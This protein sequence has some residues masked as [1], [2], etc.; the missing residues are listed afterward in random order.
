[1]KL[2]YTAEQVQVIRYNPPHAAVRLVA[3]DWLTLHAEVERLRG[4][5]DALQT[6]RDFY[7]SEVDRQDKEHRETLREFSENS[8]HTTR[9]LKAQLA[10]A[11]EE[12]RRFS[13]TVSPGNGALQIL[14]QLHYCGWSDGQR[15]R[16]WRD[17]DVAEN[18]RTPKREDSASLAALK[19]L[20]A[21]ADE[22]T[23]ALRYHPTAFS[24][25]RE[26]GDPLCSIP[27][28][29]AP[30]EEPACPDCGGIKPGEVIPQEPGLEMAGYL[31]M[32][33]CT[34]CTPESREETP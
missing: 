13:L 11:L 9:A 15:A 27:G 10:A 29:G 33:P 19:Q 30:E 26:C 1:M 17:I 22:P 4:E 25:R 31:R 28:C 7:S 23:A 12:A 14:R 34:R 2:E 32:S 21:L 18:I 8:R 16:D 3:S 20:M 24:H 6:A 5:R